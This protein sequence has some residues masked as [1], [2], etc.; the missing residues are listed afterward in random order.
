MDGPRTRLT[1]AR[2]LKERRLEEFAAQEEARGIGP[3]SQTDL[4][5]A[6]ALVIKPRRSEGQTSRS[7]SRGGSAGKRTR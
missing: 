2:A 4:E 7:S 6:L 1:L 5:R 3:A